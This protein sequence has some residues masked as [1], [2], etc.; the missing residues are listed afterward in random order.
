MN[1]SGLVTVKEFDRFLRSINIK[2]HQRTLHSF[3]QNWVRPN[4][5]DGCAFVK[6][7]H[8]EKNSTGTS[9]EDGEL[10]LDYKQFIKRILPDDYPKRSRAV[11]SKDIVRRCPLPTATCH[12]PSMRNRQ[13]SSSVVSNDPQRD[14]R[15]IIIILIL[16]PHDIASPPITH[17]LVQRCLFVIT[18]RR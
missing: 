10:A 15:S 8:A 1:G 17:T 7:E 3:F 12:A 5:Q 13:Q 11:Y 2:V 14:M 9:I 16:W 6:K 18:T 4:D